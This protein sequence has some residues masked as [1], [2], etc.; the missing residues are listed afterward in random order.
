[1]PKEE[2]ME[3]RKMTFALILI[4]ICIVFSAVGQVLMKMGMNQIGAITNIQQL[5]NFK[6][7]FSIFTNLCVIAGILCFV[8][9][10][11]IWLAAMST[12]NISFMYPLASLVYALTAIIALVFLHEQISLVRWVGIFLIVGGCFFVGQ[13]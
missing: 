8:I 6:M 2:K 7:M 10:L 4:A 5:L 12:L 1:M 13:S 9:Q 11:V 3:K